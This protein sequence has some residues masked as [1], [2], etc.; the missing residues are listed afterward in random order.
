MITRTMVLRN[1]VNRLWSMACAYDG[2]DASGWFFVFSDDNPYKGAYDKA[3]TELL[4]ERGG[5]ETTA[6]V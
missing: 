6:A 5:D 1:M 2:F 4:S 3:L